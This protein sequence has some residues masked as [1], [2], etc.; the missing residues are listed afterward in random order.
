MRE[1]LTRHP[2]FL[3]EPRQQSASIVFIDLSGFTALS[4]T[5]EPN[6]TREL[7]KSFHALVDKEAVA[8]GGVITS[9]MGDGAMILFGLP[10]PR[11]EDPANAVRCCVNL[12]H[13]TERWLT[14]LTPQLRRGSASKLERIPGRSSPHGLVVEATSTSPQQEIR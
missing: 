14:S 2:D 4:E 5:L 11:A 9:F 13:D 3:A 7:L 10:E 12:C 8:N 6:D 1:W